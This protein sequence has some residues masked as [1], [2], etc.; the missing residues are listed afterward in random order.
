MKN[1]E[2]CT[3]ALASITDDD[4]LIQE[5]IPGREFT[6]G[7]YRDESGIHVLPIIEIVTIAGEFFDFAEKYESDGSNEVFASLSIELTE[8]LTSKSTKIYKN[9]HCR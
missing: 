1:P 3:R 8:E 4:V 6:V 2:E 5:L 7:V 9:L